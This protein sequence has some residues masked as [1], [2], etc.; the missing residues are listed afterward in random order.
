MRIF[1][2]AATINSAQDIEIPDPD[3]YSSLEDYEE[4]VEEYERKVQNSSSS[5]SSQTT[6]FGTGQYLSAGIKDNYNSR[7][8]YENFLKYFDALDADVKQRCLNSFDS[9]E[10]LKLQKIVADALFGSGKDSVTFKEMKKN[11]GNLGISVSIE[12]VDTQYRVDEFKQKG[13]YITNGSIALITFKD[14]NGGEFTVADANGNAALETDELF[15]N[16]ILGGVSTDIANMG[17]T[18]TVGTIET[19]DISADLY[20]MIGPMININDISETIFE[21]MTEEEYNEIRE[22]AIEEIKEK[23]KKYNPELSDEEIND[24]AEHLVNVEISLPDNV[25]I[26]R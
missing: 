20:E 1:E 5:T 22:D 10:D 18:N 7:T 24:L 15:M 17:A 26:V 8:G 6:S 23:L 12:Y 21:T 9:P 16:E 3:D 4:A 11:L 2:T 13:D 19:K 25:K 14:A